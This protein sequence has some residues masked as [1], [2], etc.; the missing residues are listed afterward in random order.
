MAIAVLTGVG[1]GITPITAWS[2]SRISSWVTSIQVQSR[3]I[4]SAASDARTRSCDPARPI[5]MQGRCAR[6][7]TRDESTPPEKAQTP[8]VL[9][10]L[11]AV[12]IASSRDNTGGLGDMFP[13]FFPSQTIVPAGQGPVMIPKWS[14]AMQPSHER[15]NSPPN[16]LTLPGS[17]WSRVSSSRDESSMPSSSTQPFSSICS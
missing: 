11:T 8:S 15:K 6:N 1:S 2:P 5:A 12:T 7:A 14:R 17:L 3:C 9:R 13:V 10:S 4:A 16:R